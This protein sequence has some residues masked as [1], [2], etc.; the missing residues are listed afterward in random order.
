MMS[1]ASMLGM[2]KS[3]L[4]TERSNWESL[5]YY[6]DDQWHT[7]SLDKKTVKK[8]LS[9]PSY[10]TYRGILQLSQPKVDDLKKIVYKYVPRESREFYDEIIQACVD[11]S[12]NSCTE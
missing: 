11:S 2:L 4:T 3:V 9:F 8:P 10:P 6:D 5:K 1:T 7:F 12:E